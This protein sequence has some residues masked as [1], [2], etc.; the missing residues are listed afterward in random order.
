[1]QAR[2]FDTVIGRLT[3][4]EDDGVL[5]R[6]FLGNQERPDIPEGSSPLLLSV[7][8]QIAEYLSG[9]RR[10]FDI[11]VD[12]RRT[13]F[14][15]KVL[16]ALMS[17][18]YGTTVSYSELASMSG[19]ERAY[20]ATGTVCRTNPVPIII[21]CHRVLPSS[22]KIGMYAGTPGVKKILLDMEGASY[23]E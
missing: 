2:T 6:L 9:I 12:H 4:V 15:K 3:A 17:V 23:R 22:G 8:R 20:R 5:I 14:S 18:P 7:E 11:P 21:P 1:M 10:T 16:D 13:G 19:N